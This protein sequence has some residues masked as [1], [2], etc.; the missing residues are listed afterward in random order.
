MFKKEAVTLAKSGYNVTVYTRAEKNMIENNV[1]IKKIPNYNNR[2]KRFILQPKLL[3]LILKE[4]AKVIHLHNPDT[5][6]IGFILKLLGKKVVYDTHE[7]FTKRIL[8]RKWIPVPLR[9]SLARFVKYLELIASKLFDATFVTQRDILK[10]MGNKAQ[11]IENA[12][13]TEGNIVDEAYHISNDIEERPDTFRSIYIGAISENRGLIEVIKSIKKLNCSGVK[14]R[15]W[16]AGKCYKDSFMKELEGIDGWE[17]VDY[18]GTLKQEEAFAYVIK[19]DVGFITIYDVGDHSKTS[20]NKIFEYMRFSIPF[21]ASNFNN[22]KERLDSLNAGLFVDPTSTEEIL[23]ALKWL[24]NNK[25]QRIIM[26][27]NG[28]EYVLRQ[29]NW[30]KESEKLLK[31]YRELI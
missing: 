8:I 13:I 16:L 22:W 23:S 12:P 6:L 29:Y 27:Q 15:L 21:I 26:G 11:L 24:Y 5:L 9:K 28:K 1:T 18:L 7:D 4:R 3:Y 14:S 19:S 17:Y 10:R 25:D 31:V 20:P 30:E 2:L